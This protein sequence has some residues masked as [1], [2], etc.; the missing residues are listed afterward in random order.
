MKN[1]RPLTLAKVWAVERIVL[2][3]MLATIVLN[4]PKDAIVQTDYLSDMNKLLTEINKIIIA[5]PHLHYYLFNAFNHIPKTGKD[6]YLSYLVAF[7]ETLIELNH[8]LPAGDKEDERENMLIFD[9]LL[10]AF[11]SKPHELTILSQQISLLKEDMQRFMLRLVSHLLSN[12]QPIMGLDNLVKYLQEYP[13]HYETL[14]THCKTPPYPTLDTLV[15]WLKAGRFAL[16]YSNHSLRPFGAR[17]IHYAF[18]QDKY[19]AQR[20]LFVGPS[21]EFFSDALAAKLHTRLCHHRTASIEDLKTAMTVLRSKVSLSDEEKLELLCICIEMLAR[22][23]PQFE[24][25]VQSLISQEV[26]TTQVMAL[27]SILL[28]KHSKHISEIDTGEGKSRIMMILAACQA[29][30]GKTVDFLSSDM[31][32]A[33]RDYLVYNSFFTALGIKTSL[34]SMSTPKQLYQRGGV[35]FSDNAQLLLLRNRCDI[36]EDPFAFLDQEETKRCLL[37]DE[38]DKFI[39]DRAKDAFN[40][41]ARSQRLSGFVWVYPHLVNFV[42]RWEKDNGGT[43]FIAEELIDSFL[44]YVT[45]YDTDVAHQA[46]LATIHQAQLTTWL[47]AAHTAIHLQEDKH[48]RTT[49]ADATKLFPIRDSEGRMRYSRKILVLDNGRP[50]EGCSF[51]DGVQQCLCV[52]ENYKAKQEV[53]VIPPENETQCASYPVSFMKSYERGS[54]YGVSGTTRSEN[55]A[56]N[57][58]NFHYE[59][60]PRE[61]PLIR[62]DKNHWV[63]KDERQQ[64]A[65]IKRSIKEQFAKGHPVLLICKDDNQSKALYHALT[66]DP[67]LRRLIKHSQRIHAL[68]SPDEEKEAIHRAGSPGSLTVSTAGMFGRGVDIHAAHLFVAAA[69]VPTFADDKQIKGRTGRIGKPGEY[70][71]IINLND[72]DCPLDGTTFNIDHVIDKAQKNRESSALFQEEVTK[73]YANFLRDSPYAAVID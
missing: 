61:K 33:R 30:Q 68:S 28:G 27:Y 24:G 45:D 6:G 31:A 36:A 54:I 55:S 3:E 63:A 69:Y 18:H 46:S 60:V 29:A 19:F 58:E 22:T 17:R 2:Q 52:I 47:Y 56:I 23:T 15:S 37:I 7:V 66:T 49:E 64:I 8:Q 34:V 43:L 14:K 38:V 67:T 62:E 25:S 1:L 44:K 12:Q 5:Q 9:A 16:S 10:A 21:E 53:F 32:L 41:A 4:S 70:R 71:M 42:N 57:H 59:R 26:N 20:Q 13:E 48:Y 72:P 65:F 11:H 40:Y 50:L 51:A 39:H 73:L 35:N